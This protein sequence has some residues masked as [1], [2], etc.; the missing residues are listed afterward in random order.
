MAEEVFNFIMKK[1][2]YP[3][4]LLR[5]VYVTVFTVQDSAIYRAMACFRK[6]FG[7]YADA[8]TSHT[9]LGT[10]FL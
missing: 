9:D 4:L 8:L 2:L 10:R 6:E 7:I 3:F 1:L 5:S